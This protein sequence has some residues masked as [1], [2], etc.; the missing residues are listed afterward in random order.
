M[1]QFEFAGCPIVCGQSGRGDHPAEAAQYVVPV[2][3]GPGPRGE[4]EAA[5]VRVVLAGAPSPQDGERVNA[6]LRHG[7]GTARFPGL[8]VAS[9]PT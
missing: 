2:E 4:D 5:A 9:S 8:G 7:Q 1:S 3:L 6:S